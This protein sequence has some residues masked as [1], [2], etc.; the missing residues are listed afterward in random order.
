MRLH[1]DSSCLFRVVCSIVQGSNFLSS[2]GGT[3]RRSG[4]KIHRLQDLGSSILPPSTFYSKYENKKDPEASSGSFDMYI[5][6]LVTKT[7]F[8]VNRSSALLM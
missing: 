3:G 6:L 4:L 1:A 7:N 8:Q 2:D 5:K